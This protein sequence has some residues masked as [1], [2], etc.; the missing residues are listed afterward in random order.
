MLNKLNEKI[1]ENMPLMWA[2]FMS[3]GVVAYAAYLKSMHDQNADAI[4]T[5]VKAYHDH[6]E[7]TRELFND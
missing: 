7:K 2:G 1:R 3:V 6:L 5:N 4:A